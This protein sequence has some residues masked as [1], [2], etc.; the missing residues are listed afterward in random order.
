[1]NPTQAH[2]FKSLNIKLFKQMK[3][4]RYLEANYYL[5]NE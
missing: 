2:I 4:N 5:L 3:T 1:M